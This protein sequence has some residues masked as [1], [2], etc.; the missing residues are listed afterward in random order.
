MQY[1]SEKIKKLGHSKHIEHILH[2]YLFNTPHTIY[3]KPTVSPIP[4]RVT[5]MIMAIYQ[6]QFVVRGQYMAR[7]EIF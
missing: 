5:E 2:I 1:S 7:G 6:N 3:Y 4:R